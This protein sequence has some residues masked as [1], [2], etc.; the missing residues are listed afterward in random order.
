MKMAFKPPDPP[1]CRGLPLDLAE[2]SA[3]RAPLKARAP[4]DCLFGKSCTDPRYCHDKLS[5][6]PSVCSGE[7]LSNNGA[8]V[9]R[10]PVKLPDTR[11]VKVGGTET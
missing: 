2:A 7:I 5:V 9:M 1:P 3:A 10:N 4:P 8:A 6:C 11:D